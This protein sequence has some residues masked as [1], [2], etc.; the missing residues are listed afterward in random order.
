MTDGCVLIVRRGALHLTRQV[1]ERFFHQLDTVVLLRDGGDL[2]I[3]PVR[4]QAAGGYVIKLRSGAGD[5]AVVAADFFRDNGV[6]DD[7]QLTLSATWDEARAALIA[8][9]AF[10]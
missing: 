10:E 2:V 1:Y 3:L 5:R 7:V 4:H 8:P 9:G 6:E